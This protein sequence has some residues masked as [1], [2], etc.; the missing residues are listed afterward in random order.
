MLCLSRKLNEKIE[1]EGGIT[2]T[3]IEIRGNKVRLGIEAPKKTKI[4]RPDAKV[5]TRKV[6]PC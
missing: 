6:L 5:K 3:V 2:I 4:V 1:I